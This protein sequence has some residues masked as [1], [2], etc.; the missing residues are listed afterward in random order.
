MK[1]ALFTNLVSHHQIPLW[2]AFAERLEQDFA[3]VAWMPLSEERRRLGWDGNF[4]RE[5]LV[6]AWVSD[7]QRRRALHVFRSA[8]VVIW[9]YAPVAEV[10]RR[11]A[12]GKLTFCCSERIFKTRR[13]RLFDPRVLRGVVRRYVLTDG[14]HHHLLSVGPYCADD[15]RF[16]RTF[17]RRMW[18]WGYFPEIPRLRAPRTSNPDPII[19]WAGRMIP[20]KR[21][22]LLLAAIAWVRS[23]TGRGF[24]L[25]LIGCGPDEER[26]R[27]LSRHLGIAGLC[28]FRGPMR[29]GAVG[30]AME[31]ADI[32]VL[33]SDRNEGWGVVVSEAMARACC[34]VGSREAGS[35][36][37]LI[38]DHVNGRTFEGA[39]PRALGSV[40]KWCI[41]NPDDRQRLGTAARAT[42]SELWS[43]KVAADR[44]LELLEAIHSG[45]PARFNDGGP[46]SPTGK[47]R[48]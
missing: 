27:W 40:L 30:E 4:S 9:G 6:K 43:P 26:L 25:R 11:I 35:V 2:Q 45:L 3:A 1:L 13:W 16:I 21:V 47:V 24:R 38:D 44:L 42:M 37:W 7:A 22:D 41:E 5:W 28:Q 17:R 20:W 36:P 8:D 48:R 10:R 33:S 39:E 23:R 32:C 31:E 14:S 19:L 34:V 46:C 18:R 29:P 15:F 12:N